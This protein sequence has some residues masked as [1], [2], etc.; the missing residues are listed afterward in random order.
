MTELCVSFPSQPSPAPRGSAAVA[1]GDS[2]LS[3]VEREVIALAADDAGQGIF[4]MAPE[5][6]SRLRRVL[7]L[8]LGRRST[9]SFA[10]PRLDQLYRFAH[11]AARGGEQL[12]DVRRLRDHGFGAAQVALVA[13]ISRTGA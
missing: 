9:T 7:Y 11:V 12:G 1:D 13:R 3:R 2:L 5:G 4:A 6:W 10:D 8:L